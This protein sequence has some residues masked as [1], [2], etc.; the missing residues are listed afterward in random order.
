MVRAYVAPEIEPEDVVSVAQARLGIVV[1]GF[2][3]GAAL[4]FS[5]ITALPSPVTMTGAILGA[6]GLSLAVPPLGNA[7]L[8]RVVVALALATGIWFAD[9]VT[10]AAEAGRKAKLSRG[11][12][13]ERAAR[14]QQLASRGFR[15]FRNLD[16]AGVDF[17]RLQLTAVLFD[18]SKLRG[19]SFRGAE[20]AGTSF[21]D[22]DVAGADFSGADLRGA[23]TSLA[24]GW[25]EVRC[26]ADTV[27]PEGWLCDEGAPL[28]ER[29]ASP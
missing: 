18:H 14:V 1:G 9:P 25:L 21:A 17:S 15:D 2:A 27:M 29:R 4:V 24:Q 5:Y 16:F 10:S 19:A 20:L 13:R 11:T 26:D 3:L 8:S 28:S 22:A 23:E 7:L 12:P 6:V